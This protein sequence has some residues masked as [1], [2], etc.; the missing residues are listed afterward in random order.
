M[1]MIFGA[2]R[3]L[4]ACSA[5]GGNPPATNVQ[6]TWLGDTLT[7]NP[8]N[9]DF[10]Q[11]VDTGTHT[12]QSDAL[13]PNNRHLICDLAA[14]SN[15]ISE[16]TLAPAGAVRDVDV[17]YIASTTAVDASVPRNLGFVILGAGDNN[18]KVGY[19]LYFD[20]TTLVLSEYVANSANTITTGA[21]VISLNTLYA[22][23]FRAIAEG[24]TT[25][26]RA[27]VWAWDADGLADEPGT[28]L[29]D[30]TDASITAPGF[31]GPWSQRATGND[32]YH[33]IGISLGVGG[34]AP[35][36]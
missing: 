9:V 24:A 20:A 6:Y 5:S 25:R 2:H 7:A 13:L 14:N 19:R 16:L 4:M 31:L 12:I 36:P 29:I 30:T 23:R 21:F 18:N 34:V 26:L 11:W 10:A 1:R 3:A 35:G 33:Y 8:A 32:R 27:K 22:V 28:W 15:Q 17:L